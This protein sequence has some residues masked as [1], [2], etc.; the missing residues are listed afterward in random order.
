MISMGFVW[1]LDVFTFYSVI[2]FSWLIPPRPACKYPV[3]LNGEIPLIQKLF[4]GPVLFCFV[5]TTSAVA[6]TSGGWRFSVL[7]VLGL[8]EIPFQ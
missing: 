1:F 6:E 5:F 2:E 3:D 4:L 8:G 7:T